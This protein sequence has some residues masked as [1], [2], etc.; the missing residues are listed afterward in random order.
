MGKDK[1]EKCHICEMRKHYR[2]ELD[3]KAGK[4]TDKRE[5]LR[6]ASIDV[7]NKM[8][9]I[10]EGYV[11]KL[12]ECCGGRV[13]S[14]SDHFLEDAEKKHHHTC[15]KCGK[16]YPEKGSYNGDFVNDDLRSEN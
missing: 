1:L 13:G 12:N 11:D 5:A 9:V 16:R 7:N 8:K 6:T 10:S 4:G 3:T 15:S 14:V 2:D